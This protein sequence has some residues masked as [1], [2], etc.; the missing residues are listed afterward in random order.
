MFQTKARGKISIW[1]F[2]GGLGFQA[3][4]IDIFSLII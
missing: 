3:S 2:W 4:L 1:E